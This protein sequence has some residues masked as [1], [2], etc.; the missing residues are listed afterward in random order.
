MKIG[1]SLDLSLPE[2]EQ[3]DNSCDNFER[4]LRAGLRPSIEQFLRS[5]GA[6]VRKRLLRELILLDV[7]YRRVAGQN[8]TRTEYNARFRD[9]PEA[10][11]EAFENSLAD[12]QDA[13]N[14]L[15]AIISSALTTRT[16]D[17]AH[18]IGT[19]ANA[20]ETTID[21]AAA[22]PNLGREIG[23]YRLVERLGRGGQG[24]VYRAMH[25]AIQSERAIKLLRPNVARNPRAVRRFLQEAQ[26]AVNHLAHPNI[27][28]TF[29]LLREDDEFYLVMELI[30]G[31]DLSHLVDQQGPLTP[32]QAAQIIEEAATGL[33][34]AHEMGFVH[35]DIK[36]QNLML[37]QNGTVKILDLGLVRSI[38]PSEDAVTNPE[39]PDARTNVRFQSAAAA[40]VTD[41]HALLGTLQYMPPEQIRSSRDADA[42]SDLYSLGCTLY[43][44]LTGKHAFDAASEDEIVAAVT[45]NRFT[46][47]RGVRA[48]IPPS[49]ESIVLRLM[50]ARPED[51]FATAKQLARA[52]RSWRRQ[53][54]L[55]NFD[56]YSESLAYE[57][58][59]ELK[60]ILLGLRIVSAMDWEQA[61]RRPTGMTG[62]WA[63]TATVAAH[64]APALP[65]RRDSDRVLEAMGVLYRDTNGQLGL[66]EWQKHHI[67]S[68]RSD[69]LRLPQ[70]VLVDKIG[71]G[72]KGEVFLARN[73]ETGGLEA[74]RTF[75]ASA[76]SGLPGDE[77]DRLRKFQIASAQI[78]TVPHPIFPRVTSFDTCNTRIHPRLAYLATEYVEGRHAGEF[79]F[80]KSW[81]STGHRTRWALQVCAQIARGLEVS[82]RLGLLHLDIHHKFIRIDVAGDVKLLD[83]GVAK[84]VTPR[85]FVAEPDRMCNWHP[86]LGTASGMSPEEFQPRP[87]AAMMRSPDERILGTPVVMPP[88]QWIDRA[89]VS[90]QTDIYNLGCVLCYLIRGAYPFQGATALE[91]MQKSVADTKS[92]APSDLPAAA[93]PVIEQMLAVKPRN[94]FALAGELADAL[95]R[96]AESFPGENDDAETK[97]WWRRTWNQVRGRE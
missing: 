65:D 8:P 72:W 92:R 50:S 39:L 51:R 38:E 18:Q 15:A 86:A 14:G 20:G 61:V 36:P 79:V 43:F 26:A 19:G 35:R 77:L 16:L 24:S 5:V 40:R 44:L 31:R 89:N 6:P 95:E 69:L 17:R 42:R 52:L 94:R 54:R 21:S 13:G 70:H 30:S 37:A 74:V 91:V 57:N 47:P 85:Q 60:E 88:E 9:D 56:Q 82:H 45:A 66:S 29:D 80:A 90:R 4:A 46:P 7:E 27:V 76:L 48:E 23:V 67:S 97:S 63:V 10:V 22:D 25:T 53:E 2:W 32:Y 87:R 83:L 93:R 78:A 34:Y 11:S 49:L 71:F 84:M 75:S 73:V 58:S 64:G 68:E 3:V 41:G 96:T 33:G 55:E 81:K 1:S 28:K 59:D 62:D 12:M